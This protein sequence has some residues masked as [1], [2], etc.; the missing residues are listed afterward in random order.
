MELGGYNPMVILADADLDY[1][2]RVAN[3]SAF[4]HQG[5]MCMNTR[6][7]YIEQPLYDEF[8]A[9]LA[10]RAAALPQGN[11]LESEVL[12]GPLI[13][14]H[15][16]EMM[17]ERIADAVSKGAKII[18][19][20]KHHGR[21]HEPTIL[22]DVPHDAAADQEETF[23]PLLIVQ[24]VSNAYEAVEGINRSLYGLTASVLTADAYR[25]FEIATRIKSGMAHVNAPTL[26]GVEDAALA[27]FGGVRNSGWGRHGEH[28]REFLTDL[29]WVT[30]RR[31][32]VE[33]P[34]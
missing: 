4:F 8:V 17:E 25:G 13:N 32:Q 1:A 15:A 31:D 24:P 5:Q 9:R 3:Y 20:G 19:G 6:K 10:E 14:D 21:V 12:I 22:T 34:I 23:G 28:A 27:P 11:P 2:V 18:T 26:E 7:V 33:V 30:V 16:V 29:I